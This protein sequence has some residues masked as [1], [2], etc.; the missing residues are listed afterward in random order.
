MSATTAGVTGVL[1]DFGITDI[2]AGAIN[3]YPQ[4]INTI[5]EKS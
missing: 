5:L 4:S 2:I 3:K 1:L